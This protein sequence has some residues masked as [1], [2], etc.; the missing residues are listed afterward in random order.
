M[1]GYGWSPPH[2]ATNSDSASFDVSSSS[3]ADSTYGPSRGRGTAARAAASAMLALP[4]SRPSSRASSASGRTGGNASVGEVILYPP[5]PNAGLA[6]AP[7][8]GLPPPAMP[9]GMQL[10]QNGA[11]LVPGHIRAYGP[12]AP[13]DGP[14]YGQAG[15]PQLEA[16]F[17][18]Q[19]VQNNL[20]AQ[21]EANL[22]QNLFV[23]ADPTEVMHFAAS[24]AA[25]LECSAA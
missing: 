14:A 9:G 19:N 23:G 20:H 1:A 12:H 6:V 13:Y 21:V 24:A 16:T 25:A 22:Q 18:Q 3:T 17:V 4:S 10:A 7:P 2:T 11:Q 15:G 5:P 8:P